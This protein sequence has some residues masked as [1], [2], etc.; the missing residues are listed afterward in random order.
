MGKSSG[1]ALGAPGFG[2]DEVA[3]TG[4]EDNWHCRR[5]SERG[6]AKEAHVPALKKLSALKL[7]SVATLSEK[8]ARAAG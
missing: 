5:Q 8:S 4:K 7:T 1:A 2:W 3:S 6:S